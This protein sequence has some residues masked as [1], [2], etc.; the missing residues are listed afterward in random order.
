MKIN[1]TN[2]FLY[3]KKG[4]T[5]NIMR[6]FIFLCCTAVFS[7]NPENVL[8]QNAK[9]KID[10]DKTITVDEVFDLIM[11]QTDYKFIYDEELFKNFP[12]VNLYK[13][14]IPANTLL[15]Q[16]LASGSFNVKFSSSNTLLILEKTEQE[17]QQ[18]IEISG[19]VTDKNGMPLSGITVYVSSTEPYELSNNDFIVR[20]TT[21]DF[22]GKFTLKTAVGHYLVAQGLGYEIFR[23]EIVA[24][25][26]VYNITLKESVSTLEEVVLVGYGS[27]KRKNITGAVSSINQD[28]LTINTAATASF[29]RGLGGMLKGVNVSQNS[30]APGSGASINIRGITSPLLGD[31]ESSSNQPLYV[32]DGVIFNTDATFNTGGSTG[33]RFIFPAAANPLLSLDPNNIE[34]IDVLKD[35]GATAIYGSR[36]ANGVILVTTKKGKKNEAATVQ[37]SSQTSFGKPINRLNPMNSQQYGEYTDLIFRNS[38]AAANSGQISPFSLF[39]FANSPFSGPSSIADLDLDFFTFQYTYNGLNPDFL[40]SANTDW[41]DEIY[42]TSAM[43]QQYNV[44]IR[45]GSDKSTYAF[46]GS[47]MD[48]EGLKIN[49]NYEQFNFYGNLRSELNKSI[50]AGFN[51]NLGHTKRINSESAFGSGTSSSLV[52]TRPD[53]PV[54]DADGNFFRY[55]D[56][57]FGAAGEGANPVATLSSNKNKT[58]G[59]TLTSK[60]FLEAE[61]LKNVKVKADVNVGLF[62]TKVSNFSGSEGIFSIPAFNFFPQPSL[63]TASDLNINLVTNLT[64]NYNNTFGDHTINVLGGFAWDRTQVERTYSNFIEGFLDEEVLNTP[65]NLTPNDTDEGTIE[66]GL[67]SAFV[68][69]FYSYKNLLDATFNFRSD[70]SSKFAPGNKRAYFPAVSLGWNMH[71]QSFLQSDK[72]N[73][74]KLRA[75]WGKTGSTNLSEFAYLQFFALGEL[76]LGIYNG[77]P[78]IQPSSSLPNASIGWETTQEFNVGFDFALL[79]N[80]LRGSIDAYT[81]ETTD[82]LSPGA[83]PQELGPNVFTE[84]FIEMSNKGLEIELGGDIV[85]S[86]EANGFNWST[87]VNWALNRN[88]VKKLNSDVISSFLQD[89]IVVGEPAGTLKGYKVDGIFQDQAV[90]DQL[91]ANAA[92]VHGAGTVYDQT[93]TS[94]GDYRFTDTNNDG[95]INTDD[96]V[97]IGNV[98]PDF[99]GGFTNRFSYK[100]FELN[101][102]FQFSVGAEATWGNAN[103]NSFATP[104]NNN[105]AFYHNNTWTPTNTDAQYPRVVYFDPGSNRR[106]NEVFDASY[107]RLKN[108]QLK[109]NLPKDALSPIGLKSGS[110]FVAASNLFTIT[111]WPGLDPESSG[112]GRVTDRQRNTDPYPLSKTISFGINVQF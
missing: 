25:Q 43:T 109:Y 82:G 55:E 96:R 2:A 30:G 73:Q 18:E 85:R 11:E 69:A 58:R 6:A 53:V 64:A 22:D 41:H 10:T 80:R 93:G 12:K 106:F 34:S 83:I 103:V 50:T 111:D 99:F 68:Q 40:G 48:Q 5:T 112:G 108:I 107:L 63:T 28:D 54:R 35:A 23:Q 38:V 70:A 7:L 74:L 3:S 31:F 94:P 84:N 57:A 105:Q 37:F 13:G 75:S 46:G 9:I 61:V 15:S 77:N 47:Y 56:W 44:N 89:A 98:Q 20:G 24:N 102:F 21:T 59:Y 95:I 88:E 19:V 67:N 36:G 33:S 91:N 72:I 71:N 90:I 92:T 101:A 86:N 17:K 32:I 65:N 76:G 62:N 39:S 49:D 1:S 16:S 60:V 110:L 27:Q 79:N 66:V 87:T 52:S 29:D 8:S 51:I 26:T 100:G 45:G 4:L 104:G 42:N 97:V 81:R 78:A 14:Y